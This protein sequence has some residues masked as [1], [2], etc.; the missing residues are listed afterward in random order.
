MAFP[1]PGSPSAGQ[2]QI[3]IALVMQ[4]RFSNQ[5][6]EASSQIKRLHQEAKA[7]TNAN[8]QVARNLSGMGA[9]IG[10]AALVGLAGVVQEGANFIDTMTFV[11]AIAQ[12]S[13]VTMEQLGY[14]A[15]ALGA[16]TMFMA[17]DVASAMQYF[18]MAG[19][20]TSEIYSNIEAAVNLAGATMSELGGKGGTADILTNIMRMFQITSSELASNR[21]ADVLTTA[22]TS[23]NTNLYDLA[24]AIKYAG[25]TVKNLGGSIEQTSAF[26]GVLGD[27]GIQGSMAG[28]AMANAYRY[29]TRSVE[30]ANFKGGKALRALGLGKE[31]FVTAEGKLIDLGLAMQKISKAMSGMSD[32][33]RFNQLVAILG[34][35]G[36]RGGSTMMKAFERYTELLD[37]VQTASQGKAATIMETRMGT[38]AG[39]LNIMVSALENVRVTFV[40][41]LAPVLS[42]IFATLGAI[43]NVVRKILATPFLGPLIATTLTFG[44]LLITLKLGIIALRTS[45]QIMFNDSTISF[46]NMIAVMKQGW[47]SATMS[48]AQYRAMQAGIIAQQKAGIV[49]NA[50]GA[51]INRGIT[52]MTY[53][54][55][56]PGQR[57]AGIFFKN[58]RYYQETGRGATG[59]TRI[60][61][62]AAANQ[63][64]GKSLSSMG[65]IAKGS[66][67]GAGAALALGRGVLPTIAR[68]LSVGVR[69]LGGPIGLGLTAVSLLLPAIINAVSN[70]SSSRDANTAALNRNTDY[71][72]AEL[73]KRTNP[74]SDEE[75]RLVI[76]H[77]LNNLA[78]TLQNKPT[79]IINVYSPEGQLQSQQ[80]IVD[81]QQEDIHIVGSK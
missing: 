38:L 34:V 55:Q 10:G 71:R 28:T 50:A 32:T 78:E 39:T 46:A 57:A 40:E 75:Q 9:A 66:A 62:Q 27:A 22:V 59:V 77:A 68:A 64:A 43:F 69:F 23:S 11:D 51:A 5:A 70:S 60:S 73:A 14:K 79:A 49:S 6:R 35:R 80:A 16:D 17:R 48:A 21:V 24:E 37:K 12:K 52:G 4:D 7:V 33:E 15:K 31:D 1:A 29:L 41:A 18:A 36:E 45:M 25:T 19:M 65:I 30:D 26:I 47:S 53:I 67:A 81:G 76:A 20:T 54:T 13:G 63:L 61:Q 72:N 3:G 2:L 58:G 44:T 74:L 42:P 56:N 8:L